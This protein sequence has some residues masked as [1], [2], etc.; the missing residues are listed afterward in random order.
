[1][2]PR[3]VP[4]DDRYDLSEEAASQ[5]SDA[6]S[7]MQS[8]DMDLDVP[9]ATVERDDLLAVLHEAHEQLRAVERLL[10]SADLPV[11]MA[12]IAAVDSLDGLHVRIAAETP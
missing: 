11:P 6:A 7:F 12:L 8:A 3:I 1:M 2:D 4:L 9:L 5:V 10:A